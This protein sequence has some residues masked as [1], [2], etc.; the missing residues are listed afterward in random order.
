MMEQ[1]LFCETTKHL[2]NIHRKLRLEG[3]T[4]YGLSAYSWMQRLWVTQSFFFKVFVY[5]YFI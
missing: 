4:Q 5:L 2:L 3:N 1:S